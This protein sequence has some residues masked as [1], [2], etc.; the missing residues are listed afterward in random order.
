MKMAR[1]EIPVGELKVLVD[2]LPEATEDT[3]EDIKRIWSAFISNHD[4][5]NTDTVVVYVFEASI[6]AFELGEFVTEAN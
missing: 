1:C 5:S 6:D 4:R 2:I 3:E